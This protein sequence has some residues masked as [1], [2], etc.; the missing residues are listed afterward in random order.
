MQMW[1]SNSLQTQQVC[2]NVLIGVKRFLILYLINVSTSIKDEEMT[3]N[4][5]KVA[6]LMIS[7]SWFYKFDTCQIEQTRH[8]ENKTEFK[9]L[10]KSIYIEH[11]CHLL[12]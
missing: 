9:Q 10:K 2:L 4:W 1:S 11:F 12:R 7:F 5:F 8:L 6:K 3:L